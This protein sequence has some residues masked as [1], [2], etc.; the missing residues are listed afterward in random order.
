MKKHT[1]RRRKIMQKLMGLAL[2]I[3]SLAL[4]PLLKNEDGTG[5][6]VAFCL[7]AYL[8]FSRR[9]CIR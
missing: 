1:M 6:I 3:M 2:V 7:G 5:A 8:L 4:V 9:L